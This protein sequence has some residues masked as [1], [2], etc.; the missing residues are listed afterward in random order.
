MTPRALLL[1]DPGP[2]PFVGQFRCA[3]SAGSAALSIAGRVGAEAGLERAFEVSGLLA[4]ALRSLQPV[5]PD[6]FAL[7]RATWEL[8]ALMP[9][10]SLGPA[11]G[12]DLCLLLLSEDPDGACVAGVGLSMV[13]ASDERALMPLVEV[14]HPLLCPAGRPSRTPGVLNLERAPHCIVGAPA[15]LP[16]TAPTLAELRARTGVRG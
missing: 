10:E 11:A 7:L 2:T 5:S 15:H 4:H 9:S 8:L 13:W 12:G 1:G 16:A 14:P 6:R 3:I